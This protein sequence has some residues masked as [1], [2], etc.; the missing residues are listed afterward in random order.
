MDLVATIQQRDG[1]YTVWFAPETP[2]GHESNWIQTIP[3][4]SYD[5]ILRMYGP[6]E[7]WFGKSWKLGDIELVDWYIE[8]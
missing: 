1:S 7:S 5:V 6:L 3:G 2:E 4:K 8:A